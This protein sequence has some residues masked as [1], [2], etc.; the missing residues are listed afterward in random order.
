MKRILYKNVKYTNLLLITPIEYRLD[1][2]MYYPI[3]MYNIHLDKYD[4]PQ[5][6]KYPLFI[7]IICRYYL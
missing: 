2:I 3:I 7:D 6:E 4:G 1:L 5:Q